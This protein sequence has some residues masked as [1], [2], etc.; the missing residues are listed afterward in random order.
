MTA[1]MWAA[2]RGHVDVINALLETDIFLD[3]TDPDGM[4]AADYAALYGYYNALYT[5]QNK[6]CPVT[7]TSD[8]L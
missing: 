5:L 3:K 1:L 4:T 7:K 6:G 2:S 8:E